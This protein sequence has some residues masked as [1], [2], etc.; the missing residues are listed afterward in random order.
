MSVIPANWYLK[1]A[2]RAAKSS[3]EELMVEVGEHTIDVEYV[4]PDDVSERA[5]DHDMYH[6]AC[7]F[8]RG[9]ANAVKVKDLPIEDDTT[10]V[11]M[12][13]EV[14]VCLQPSKEYLTYMGDELRKDAFSTFEEG[15]W[16]LLTILLVVG[17]VAVLGL[18]L[19]M[20]M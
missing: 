1:R 2:R 4:D 13:E 19:F 18:V 20:V 12:G 7:L 5:W 8:V 9:Y 14:P 10:T 15:G 16:D 17:A 11:V 6:R 3:D